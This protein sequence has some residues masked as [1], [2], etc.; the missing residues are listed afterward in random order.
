MAR[1]SW[2]PRTG[3]KQVSGRNRK[4]AVLLVQR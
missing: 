4:E 3:E 1:T 2:K